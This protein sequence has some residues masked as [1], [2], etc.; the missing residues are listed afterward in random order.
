VTT[1]RSSKRKIALY[2]GTFNPPTEGHRQVIQSV[3]DA[4]IVDNVWVLPSLGKFKK[5][6]TA[7]AYRM[8]MCE[9]AFSSMPD[10]SV[11]SLELALGEETNGYTSKVI[12]GAKRVFPHVDFYFIVGG[13]T[14]EKIP[15]KWYNGVSVAEN[16]KFITIPR[17]NKNGSVLNIPA[18]RWYKNLPN[19]YLDVI[20]TSISSTQVRSIYKDG[21]EEKLNE[22]P[23]LVNRHVCDFID[24]Y[25]FYE[26]EEQ[27][28]ARMKSAKVKMDLL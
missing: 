2:G 22:L 25:G 18:D 5:N 4:G 19:I 28:Q 23:Q 7:Y 16:E 13:D 12:E 26:K 24:R 9:L 11:S 1:H 21:S 15:T 3:L 6:S 20:P 10:V 8:A 14:A 27:W 17:L